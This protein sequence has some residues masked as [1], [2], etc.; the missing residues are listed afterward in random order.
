VCWDVQVPLHGKVAD[1]EK[2]SGQWKDESEY[3]KEKAEHKEILPCPSSGDPTPLASTR[4]RSEPPAARASASKVSAPAPETTLNAPS[5]IAISGG[6]VEN[7][8]VNNYGEM[9]LR[10]P[11]NKK[12]ELRS[13][14]SG[15][16]APVSVTL[17]NGGNALLAEDFHDLLREA[18]WD[19]GPVGSWSSPCEG[20]ELDFPGEPTSPGG[21]IYVPADTPEYEAARMMQIIGLP[22]N[23][24]RYHTLEGMILIFV[25]N[26][27]K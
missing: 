25:G 10:V 6:H 14:L 7:P 9:P 3:W 23:V 16:A 13:L 12:D 26:D 2:R 4:R 5:G 1:A 15:K 19:I 8:T 22:L 27:S 21:H 11:A 17:C 24:R 18:R 20:V